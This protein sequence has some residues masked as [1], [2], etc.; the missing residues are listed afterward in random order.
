MT[1][2]AYIVTGGQ[3]ISGTIKC[4]GAKN[5]VTKAMVASILGSTPSTLTN[6][7]AIGDTEITQEMLSSIGITVKRSG[8]TMVIDPSTLNSSRVPTPHTGSNRVPILLLGALL[9]R[10]TEVS[11]PV[12]GGCK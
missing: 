3:P 2:N 1:S 9:H 5:F 12:L 6:V 7:P 10:L 8:D 4:L 11:V